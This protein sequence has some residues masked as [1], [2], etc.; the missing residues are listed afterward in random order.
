MGEFDLSLISEF[1]RRPAFYDRNCPNF[2]DKIYNAQQWQE[3]SNILG[4]DGK[5]FDDDNFLFD[6]LFTLISVLG[7]F[8]V[9]S[10]GSDAAVAK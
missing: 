8:S 9:Y 6:N 3:I 4:F 2:K 10:K 5:I 7:I 1:R